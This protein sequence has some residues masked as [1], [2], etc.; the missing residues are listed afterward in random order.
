M[1]LWPFTRRKAATRKRSLGRRQPALGPSAHPPRAAA[2]EAANASTM[3]AGS[4]APPPDRAKNGNPRD[5]PSS[6]KLQRRGRSNSFSPGR[7]DSIRVARTRQPTVPPSPT[8]PIPAGINDEHGARAEG[9]SAAVKEGDINGRVP[10][11]HH[12]SRNKRSGQPLPGKK[13]SK[14]R[15][16][17]H[18]RE[19]EIRA[20][21]QSHPEPS[22]GTPESWTAGRSLKRS[23]KR[24]KTG[25][26]GDWRRPDSDISLAI[27]ES[28]NS[29]MSS[30]SDFISYSVSA[31]DALAPRPTIRYAANPVYGASHGSGPQR[32]MS[33]KRKLS[34]RVPIS[35]ATLKAHKRVDSLADD[36]DASDLRQLM[37]RDKRRREQRQ[38]RERERVERRLARNAERQQAAETEA[39]ENGTPPP[40]NLERGVLG[41]ESPAVREDRTSAVY[42][43]SKRRRSTDSSE[44][45][46]PREQDGRASG[47]RRDPS[48][49]DEFHRVDSIAREPQTPVDTAPAHAQ[50][51]SIVEEPG[52]GHSRSPSPRF[53]NLFRSRTRRSKSPNSTLRKSEDKHSAPGSTRVISKSESESASRPSDSG[54]SNK[55]WSSLFK[56]ARPGKSKRNS[57]PS[58]FSN[59]SRDSMQANHPPTSQTPPIYAPIQRSNSKVPKRTMS[60][61]REDLPEL[62]I[63][64]PDSRVNSPE[65]GSLPTEPLPSIPD[66]VS[67]QYDSPTSAPRATPI[68]IQRDSIQPSPAQQ[69]MSL[70]SIDS[71]GSW[72]SGRAAGKRASS[73]MRGSLNRYPRRSEDQD[74]DAVNDDD[75]LK[76]VADKKPLRQSTGEARPS[77]DEEE[78]DAQSAKWGNFARTP[79][80]THRRETMRSAQGLLMEFD[81]MGEE[82]RRAERDDDDRVSYKIDESP[83]V[84]QRA[85]SVKLGKGLVRA[86]SA[87]LLQISP[88]TSTDKRRS[89]NE[90]ADE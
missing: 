4:V 78:D 33:Q 75:F 69:S 59:T 43:S 88:R 27:P 68:P 40:Q 38:Q 85:T 41:R 77:S 70:A 80:V 25:S 9:P 12:N 64:P 21:S 74:D 58:S 76:I 7:R 13:S 22:R 42:T 56:W 14:R 63:S 17:D 79:N 82:D 44:D 47:S 32:S 67:M 18:D 72:L 62:P 23:S 31:F 61:F 89:V 90:P 34:E 26:H 15:K 1:A 39:R 83:T 84:P 48:P 46:Q 30:D 8:G 65:N 11:L 73:G 6:R 3:P 66:D 24:A 81:D 29:A 37:E 53:S 60:R 10:T 16:E 36:L 35:E 45:E 50:E 71:E 2:T 55:P 20:L 87:K 86:G 52:H 49:L 5:S 57:G 54:S 19:A 28:I 51:P